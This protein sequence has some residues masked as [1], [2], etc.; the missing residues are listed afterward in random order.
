MKETIKALIK[1]KEI[2]E[3]LGHLNK[4]IED[5][6]RILD[7][8]KLE[9]QDADNAVQKKR[10]A[11]TAFKLKSKDKEGELHSV[12]EEIKKQDNLLL[13]AK[14]NQEYNAIRDRIND[15]KGEVS[16]LEEAILVAYDGVEEDTEDLAGLERE[17]KAQEDELKDFQK[18]I[19]NE[20]DEYRKEIEEWKAKRKELTD[21]MDFKAINLYEKVKGARDG[22]AV[23]CAD[24]AMCSGCYMTITANDMARL[25]GASEIVL[26]KYCQRIL[27]LSD[28]LV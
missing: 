7:K 8:R 20:M 10:D 15:L 16:K 18:N 4:R 6:P 25:H 17:L 1:L 24:G 22:D 13:G 3:K 27:Y 19:E 23:V 28:V 11:I 2:D 26:C 14:T 21:L 5:G 12:E 9:L